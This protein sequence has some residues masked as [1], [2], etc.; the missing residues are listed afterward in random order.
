VSV[1]NESTEAVFNEA[2]SRPP[3]ERAAYLD[4][5]C[6][7]AGELRA[8]V[9]ALLAAE[10]RAG[11]FL[12][13]P[14][15]TPRPPA[16]PPAEEAGQSVGPYRLEER[17]GEGGFGVVWR[18]EQERPV[19]RDV[20]LKVLKPGMDT[21]QVIARFEAERQALAMLDHENIARVLDAG[22]TD[23]G[24]PYFV[25]ELVRGISLCEYCDRA[26]LA[27]RERIELFGDV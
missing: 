5:V 9:E 22:T 4:R 6:A 1:P 12:D 2:R 24:R 3:A 21:A 27:L 16:G 20:A 19:R 8:R 17:L 15:A 23:A 7:G 25:M 26:R 10:A 11:D 18:A 13:R 14:L